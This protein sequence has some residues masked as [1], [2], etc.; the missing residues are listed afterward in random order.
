[1][2]IRPATADDWAGIWPFWHQIALARDTY[3]L[4][5]D[6]PYEQARDMWMKETPRGRVIVA[7]IDGII[8]GTARVQPN[9]GPASR[10]ANA[11]YMV[12][13]AQSGK[14][15]GRRLVEATLDQARADGYGAMVFN[16][17]VETNANAV[18]LY[19][20]MGF[21]IIGTVPG[22]FEHPTEGLV[23]LHVMHRAL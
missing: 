9:Y 18:H 7:V 8:V 1:V 4:H 17:V 16:A 15:I 3:A 19:R 22:A 20:S 14:G 10:V 12:D 23:G 6:T 13:P 21:T 2:E 5:P 11:S